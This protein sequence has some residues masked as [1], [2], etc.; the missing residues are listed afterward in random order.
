MAKGK[1]YYISEHPEMGAMPATPESGFQKIYPKNDGNWYHLNSAS[2]EKQL[3]RYID[4]M[5]ILFVDP[6][7]SDVT[8]DG[9]PMNPFATPEHARGQANPSD[10]IT[11]DLTDT[12][13]TITDISD[14]DNAKIFIGMQI[15]HSNLPTNTFVITKGNEGGDANTI[16]LSEEATNSGNDVTLTIWTPVLIHVNPGFYE[17]VAGGYN[18]SGLAKDGVDYYFEPG[19]T[20]IKSSQGR[21]FYFTTTLSVIGT[22]VFGKGT[23]IS[24][25]ALNSGVFFSQG[26]FPEVYFECDYALCTTGTTINILS[27]GAQAGKPGVLIANI[28]KSTGG[29]GIGVGPKK[30]RMNVGEI[31][32]TADH[33]ISAGWNR[34]GCDFSIASVY[35]YSGYGIYITSSYNYININVGLCNGSLGGSYIANNDYYVTI[36]CGF[37]GL[38]TVVGSRVVIN[39]YC[40]SVNISGDSKVKASALRGTSNVI[41]GGYL[42]ATLIDTSYLTVSGGYA[43][44]NVDQNITGTYSHRITVN[45]GVL[46]LKNDMHLAQGVY[47]GKIYVNSGELHVDGDMVGEVASTPYPVELIVQSGG[48]V[49][50]RG[51]L[52]NKNNFPISHCIKKTGGTLVIAGGRFKTTH[53]DAQAINAPKSAQDIKVMSM[54]NNKSGTF[55]IITQKYKCT[56]AAV[57]STHVSLNDQQGNDIYIEET[58]TTIYNTKALLAQRMAFLINADAI[59]ITASQ[60][61]PGTDEYF[62]LEADTSGIHFTYISPLNLSLEILKDNSYL[63]TNVISNTAVIEDA[64]VE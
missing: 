26:D 16:T 54:F 36:N 63:I 51:L 25:S 18:T 15:T 39:G 61:T 12:S 20:V 53:A 11:G 31:I 4:Y 55:D 48:K 40:R 29:Y 22:K 52:H 37:I 6:N 42:E 23:F 32:S 30:L 64:E 3:G 19:A 60:D 62:Y 44:I 9:G 45:G 8:G 21:I 10:T 7:G 14:V 56:V 13:D 24:N 50:I 34:G 17:V 5:N 47:Y 46:R 59:K 1:N 35:S 49:I 33:A 41:T 28:I 43:T 2:D 57:S 38:V 58:D 27:L